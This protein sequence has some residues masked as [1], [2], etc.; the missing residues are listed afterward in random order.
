MI[1]GG[2]DSLGQY[3]RSLQRGPEMKPGS[4]DR[5]RKSSQFKVHERRKWWP[6]GIGGGGTMERRALK[7]IFLHSCPL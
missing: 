5:K 4:R 1:R 2:G 3:K 6:K 7:W